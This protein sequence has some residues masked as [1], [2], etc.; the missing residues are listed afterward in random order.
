MERVERRESRPSARFGTGGPGFARGGE[1]P[2]NFRRSTKRLVGYLKPY[3]LSISVS[4]ALSIAGTVLAIRAPKV[5]GQATTEIFRAIMARNLPFSSV[6]KTSI[7]F[8]KIR[9][10]LLTVGVL[11]GLSSLLNFVQGLLMNEV[12]QR[13]VKRMREEVNL[14]LKRLPLRFYDSRSHG[15]VMS[16]VSNDVDLIGNTLSQSLT[17]LISGFVSIVGMAYMMFTIDVGLTLLTLLTLPLS[18]LATA[19]TAIH[20]QRFF[21]QQQKHLGELSG[22]VEEVFG[23]LIVVKSYGKDRD[24]I[25]KFQAINHKLYVASHKAQF[26][27]GTIMPLMNFIGNLGYII[28][29]VRG[30][31]LVARRLITIGD[32]Q[33]FIQYSRQFN[34]PIIQIA[35]IVNLVQSTLAASERIF[36]ILD[37]GE[38][39]Q[40]SPNAVELESVKGEVSF[41]NVKFSYTTDRQLMD[42]LTIH[43]RSG[44]KVAIVGPT[45]AGKTTLVNLL[46]RFYE[47]QGGSIRLDGID[48]RDIK[49]SNLRRHFGMVLQD[50][51][52]FSG[53]VRENIA[54]G[55]PDA[56]EEEIVR[57]AKLAH[58]HHFIMAMPN[59]YD[60]AISDDATN[61]S[62]GEKQLITIARAF[63]V[64][65]DVLIL[66]EATSNVDTLTDYYIQRALRELMRNRTAFVIAHRLSTIRDADIIIVMNDG[67]VVETGTHNEL[68]EKGGFY[69]ELYRSQFLGAL[70][71]SA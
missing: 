71:E 7:D 55:K 66:D 34:Q 23:G 52:L 62:Q 50:T 28:V 5:L 44:Q 6:L 56:T 10:I 29:A 42:G 45:G 47:I 19:L 41:E 25:S 4:I 38:E 70:V 60:T 48:I 14:K 54:Y 64:D 11:Y 9:E 24:E 22:Q 65:P 33:A 15:D 51:W 8:G 40:D 49:K 17:Q 63:L 16:R 36:E 57:A 67:K 21:S 12:G 59:G 61:I 31:I 1:K 2:K 46:M 53:T 35:N 26:I 39:A 43:V 68:L 13:V 3:V 20:S 30:G 69:A 18:I 37:E 27:S 58:A 32:V